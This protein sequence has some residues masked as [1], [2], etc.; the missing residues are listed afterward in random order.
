MASKFEALVDQL[1]QGGHYDDA[2][3][4]VDVDEDSA[5]RALL[6][7]HRGIVGPLEELAY[8]SGWTRLDEAQREASP[9]LPMTWEDGWD[10]AM[11]KVRDIVAGEANDG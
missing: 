7:Y 10:Y 11:A 8:E 9:H 3:E 2:E 1:T 5:R 4:W 6:D